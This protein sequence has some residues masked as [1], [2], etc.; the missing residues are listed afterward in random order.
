MMRIFVPAVGALLIV[1]GLA[2]SSLG[3]TAQEPSEADRLREALRAATVQVRAL[4][5]GRTVLQAQLAE[6]TGE[7]DTL[8]E[9]VEVAQAE[10]KKAEADYRTAVGEF[11]ARLEER[12]VTLERWRDAYAEAADVA[13]AKDA[14]RAVFEAEAAS[15]RASTD[16]CTVK[17]QELVRVGR[18]LL[19]RIEGISLGD[20]I[21]ARE[22]LTG[23]GRVQVQNL[24]QDYGDRILNQVVQL[25]P[26]EP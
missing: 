8:Q 5:D 24:L 4:E 26:V 3:V 23:I 2:A 13:R 12:N 21:L 6:M 16:A 25:E 10:A 15:F 7:R 17:N 9:L 11:N 20:K 14:E 19:T 1:A 22:P 18:D